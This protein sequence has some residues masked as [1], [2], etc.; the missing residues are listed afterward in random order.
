MVVEFAVGL[1]GDDGGVGWRLEHDDC[2]HPLLPVA[3][4][5]HDRRLSDAGYC[6]HHTLDVLGKNV[7][8]LGR[9]DHLLLPPEYPQSARLVDRAEV[10]GAEPAVLERRLG[11]RRGAEVTGG[12]VVAFHEDFAVA[13]D[14]DLDT[15]DRRADR[16]SSAS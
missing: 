12:D 13:R 6:V 16:P 4:D 5:P 15:G 1:A 2:V 7:E 3:C 8:P 9:H 11:V 14:L 10:A